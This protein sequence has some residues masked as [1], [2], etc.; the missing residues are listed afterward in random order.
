MFPKFISDCELYQNLTLV[1]VEFTRGDGE[2]KKR[3]EKRREIAKRQV[4]ADCHDFSYCCL[5]FPL[6]LRRN[7]CL[8]MA[9]AKYNAVCGQL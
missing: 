6:V 5:Y 2:V 9:A 7:Q 4:C 1:Q 3:E 8:A